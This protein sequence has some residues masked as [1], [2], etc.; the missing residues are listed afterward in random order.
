MQTLYLLEL[1]L[2]VYEDQCDAGE[3]KPLRSDASRRRHPLLGIA[4]VAAGHPQ[5]LELPEG[6]LTSLGARDRP[7][8]R[9][10]P[11]TLETDAMA[12]VFV[13]NLPYGVTQ[14]ELELVFGDVGPV[15]KIDLIKDKGKRKSD[16]LTRG[17]AFV[18]LC[19]TDDCMRAVFPSAGAWCVG[20]TRALVVCGGGQRGGERRAAGD[21]A[22]QRDALPGPQDAHWCVG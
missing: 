8:D 6:A 21:R 11:E 15:K 22:A 14:E 3:R 10:T 18:K 9:P 19:V 16:T 12:S 4:S 5:L 7:T 2:Y 20:L 13:R 1:I 17:F